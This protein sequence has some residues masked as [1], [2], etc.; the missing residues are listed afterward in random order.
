MQGPNI[1]LSLI[2]KG[3]ALGDQ[4][5]FDEA[6]KVLDEAIKLD[7]N[8]AYAWNTKGII[9]H[10]QGMSDEA[11]KCVNEAIR[12]DPNYAYAWNVKGV[13][14]RNQGAALDDPD[15]SLDGQDKYGDNTVT[16]F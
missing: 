13:I 5:K 15:I 16:L 3:A 6:I 9:L 11:I 12:L 8:Y 7:P 10:N 1:A 14:L 2:D 4:G